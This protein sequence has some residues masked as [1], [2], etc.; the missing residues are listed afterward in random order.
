MKSVIL[1]EFVSIDGMA[2]GA[3]GSTDFIPAATRGD[4]S[5]GRRQFEFLDAIDTML[6]GRATYQLFAQY[7]PHVSSGDEKPFADRLN[8][9]RKVVFTNTLKHAP[10]GGF[11]PARVVPTSAVRE[12]EQLKQETGGQDMVVWGSLTLAKELM[13][14]GL[15]DEFQFIVCPVVLGNGRRLFED[16]PALGDMHLLSTR[17]FDRGAVLLTYAGAL[18]PAVG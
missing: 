8:A 12:I 9:L 15:V 17:S 5:F 10:W 4:Q 13:R 14:Q 6:L 18:A 1:Q 7:W 11:E 3:N 2:A 16:R